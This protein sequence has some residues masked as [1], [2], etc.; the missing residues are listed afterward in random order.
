MVAS[1]ELG[2]WR[3]A[4][5]LRFRC[6]GSY[7]EEGLE[8][9]DY[10]GRLYAHGALTRIVSREHTG[11]LERTER[12]TLE[13]DFIG[14]K[15]AW[16]PNLLSCTPTLEM[17]IDIGDLS[18]VLL[19]S[20]PPAQANY[21]QR[22]G[23]A[24]RRDG[25]ALSVAVANGRPHDLYFYAAPEEMIEG[26]V[27]PPGVFLNAA[28]VL[29]RQ[30]T[31]FCLDRW[32]ESGIRPEAIPSEL[33]SV[34]RNLEIE[35]A[36]GF[37]FNV[38]A[39]VES[40]AAELSEG[41]VGL[42]DEGLSEESRAH[43]R[44]FVLGGSHVRHE[45]LAFKLLNGLNGIAK[46]RKGL[47][48]TVERLRSR[49]RQME[50]QKVR[51]E[52]FDRDLSELRIERDALSRIVRE[53]IDSRQTLNFLTDEGLIPNYAFPEAGVLLRSIIFRKR[54]ASE[55]QD[56]Y[57]SAVYEYERPAVSAITE[58]APSNRFYAGGRNVTIDRVDLSVADV[59][60]WRLCDNCSHSELEQGDD[61][62]ATCPRCGSAQWGDAGQ[63]H[64]MIRL[65]QVFAS[66]SD[67]R[68]RTGD[69]S[70]ERN[71][72]FFRKQLLVDYADA[73]VT[74]AYSI[75][76]PELPFGFEFLSRVEFR[77]INFGEGSF[78]GA[79]VRVAG[80]EAPRKGFIICRH[81]GKVPDRK[82]ETKH[83]LSCPARGQDDESHF[84]RAVY[85]YREFASEGIRILLP[86]LTMTASDR[87]RH[88]FIAALQLGLKRRFRGKVD[89][90][91][92]TQYDE[93]IENS[94][95]RKRSLVVY[96]AVPGG[97][98]YLKELM[99]APEE[100]VEVF[101]ASL[102]ALRG[103]GC[104]QDETKDGCYR[105]LY[106]YRNA[107]DQ[108]EISRDAA[109][110]ILSAVLKRAGDLKPVAS[111]RDL[112]V[113]ALF[114]SELEARFIHALTTATSNDR[115][116]RVVPQV[117]GRS[118]GYFLSV[119]DQSWYV[120]PQV[121]LG[122][123]DGVA[124]PSRADFVI[125]PARGGKGGKP[126]AVF[127]DGWVYHKD[128]VGRDLVQRMAIL[129]SGRYH[130]WSLSWE[131]VERAHEQ[132]TA[133]LVD[134]LSGRGPGERGRMYAGL[135]E[136]FDPARGTARL[137]DVPGLST[138]QWLLRY[139]AAPEVGP[140]RD[141]ALIQML[142]LRDPVA[143]AGP[144]SRAAWM[145]LVSDS[146]PETLALLLKEVEPLLVGSGPAAPGPVR[147]HMAASGSAVRSLEAREAAFLCILD[148]GATL[149]E[150]PDFKRHWNGILRL[151]TLMQFLPGAVVLS[152]SAIHADLHERIDLRAALRGDLDADL[153]IQ[154][155]DQAWQEVRELSLPE[156]LP[157]VDVLAQTAL[158][159]PEVGY[160]LPDD[161]GAVAGMVEYAWP[162]HHLALLADTQE[163]ARPALEARGWTVWSLSAVL[164]DP[165]SFV[166]QFP[167]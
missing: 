164:T 130:V 28:A 3:R 83:T 43:I 52:N 99:R 15:E 134:H 25:N 166:S 56:G 78:D 87:T 47:V 8:G 89:H 111:L 9:P 156:A 129:R 140:W 36:Q 150:H 109:V 22:I 69:D 114:D 148:D 158:P 115:P 126:I 143:S 27:Q 145:D 55:G 71:P 79:E 39:F 132:G 113:N 162:D 50:A 33:R 49:I 142:L 165:E 21:V 120:E 75:D 161:R 24:G 101:K 151:L 100:L 88:S 97:T 51:D 92:V 110:A 59:E 29:E 23:R 146:V 118:V 96:D 30:M 66:T 136:G 58:L 84:L 48:S 6:G 77:E 102:E 41:F 70:D 60:T 67:R 14:G 152:S 159:A 42:F 20:I 160:E 91:R 93:P 35:G 154:A 163:G 103:C 81:C 65:R 86:E 74:R 11:L 147:F 26:E 137:A 95:H 105:C 139:L 53:K 128:R 121:E 85:L 72:V 45:S 119:G 7:A 98:G 135:I 10:Y 68:S 62:P 38:L 122:R 40:R 127:L 17:G 112:P 34:L 149:R 80:E 37:P 16:S 155:E 141:H 46:E 123:G 104:N 4:P 124:I 19:C 64:P 131:D 31:A 82:A 117:V 1:P 167:N 32:V 157:V 5:C 54:N 108:D 18:T 94:E 2:A 125:R 57:D 153:D 106:A 144:E 73:D 133:H 116:I 90:L 61:M 44:G 138:F 76:D 107:R 63:K 12:E 13:R